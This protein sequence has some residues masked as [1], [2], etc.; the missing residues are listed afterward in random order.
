M[1]TLPDKELFRPDEV[2]HLLRVSVKT[3]YGWIHQGKLDAWNIGP[4]ENAFKVLRV[5]KDAV[6]M[7]IHPYI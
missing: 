4:K 7:L 3:V 5:H 1:T 2:A 6:E